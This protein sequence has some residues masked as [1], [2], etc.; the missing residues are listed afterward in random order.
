MQT[1]SF[2]FSRCCL[3]EI[4]HFL[5][6]KGKMT[7]GD[8]SFASD[9]DK[10]A[11]GLKALKTQNC[12]EAR[13]KKTKFTNY[14]NT[15]WDKFAKKQPCSKQESSCG[16]WLHKTVAYERLLRSKSLKHWN[17]KPLPVL[18]DERFRYQFNSRYLMLELSVPVTAR[19]H[20]VKA[21]D[22]D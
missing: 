11:N 1:F 9:E 14:W 18:T 5:P 8:R 15:M 10:D 13:V 7:W 21:D 6:S 19:A 3:V 2:F 22:G 20:F 4:L 12:C 16:N 17:F